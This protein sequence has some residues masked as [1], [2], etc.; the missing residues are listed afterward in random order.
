[1]KSNFSIKS[2]LISGF[3][4]ILFG[5]LWTGA[6]S[7]TTMYS[8]SGFTEKMYKHS[9]TAMQG[10]LQANNAIIKI[11]RSMKEMEL[12]EDNAAMKKTETDIN[13]Y[14]GKFQRN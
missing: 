4:L 5:V 8:L 6:E 1:M 13:L 2:K 14:S 9:L 10:S 12:A 11:D 7:I 3:G